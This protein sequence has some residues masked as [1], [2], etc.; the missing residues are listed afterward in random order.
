MGPRKCPQLGGLRTLGRVRWINC[1]APSTL[2]TVLGWT[3][4]S[5]LY[6]LNWV[7]NALKGKR[8]LGA[9]LIAATLRGAGQAQPG[10]LVHWVECP[11]PVL[12]QWLQQH[13]IKVTDVRTLRWPWS[14]PLPGTVLGLPL[15]AWPYLLTRGEV[16][17]DPEL[18]GR[19]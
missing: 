2:D 17:E 11:S 9:L 13:K 4:P 18:S 15:T 19:H 10:W 16:Q 8:L 6:A 7:L 1:L 12:T 14:S 5:S 3:E